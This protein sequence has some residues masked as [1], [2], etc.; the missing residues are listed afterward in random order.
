MFLEFSCDGFSADF[1]HVS[2]YDTSNCR[3]H[4]GWLVEVVGL[5]VGL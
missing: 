1:M 2:E 3:E 4:C 5:P